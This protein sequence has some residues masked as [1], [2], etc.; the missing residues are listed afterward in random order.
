MKPELTRKI[1]QILTAN[2]NHFIEETNAL[3]ETGGLKEVLKRISDGK[4]VIGRSQFHSI[5]TIS[6]KAGSLDE[7]LL[8]ISYQESKGKK[9]D[10][11]AI[12]TDQKTVAQIV[13]DSIK[14]SVN[15]ITSS[16]DGINSMSDD[17]LRLFKL[18]IAEKHLGYLYWQASIAM[19]G[20]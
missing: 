20:E 7:L 15:E 5:M 4:P 13:M 8:F 12:C 6:A 3:M 1:Q 9:K 10:W 2:T 16:F 18:K 11:A 17:D 19:K 14:A